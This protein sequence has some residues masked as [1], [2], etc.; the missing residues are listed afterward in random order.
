M[1][2]TEYKAHRILWD[3]VE[4]GLEPAEAHAEAEHQQHYKAPTAD[5]VVRAA[6][7]TWIALVM[8]PTTAALWMK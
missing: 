6:W 7:Q 4:L 8:A 2:K 5:D 3:C 1:T